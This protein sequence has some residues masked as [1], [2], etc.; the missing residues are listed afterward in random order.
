MVGNDSHL[1]YQSI[2]N[3]VQIYLQDQP[4]TLSFYLLSIE[5]VDVVLDMKWLRTLGPIHAD[6]SI[7]PSY[8]STIT[9]QLL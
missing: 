4:L 5:G 1:Q 3:N 2:C 7:P 8:F 9:L 6:F